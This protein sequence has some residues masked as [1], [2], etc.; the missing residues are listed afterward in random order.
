MKVSLH[1]V[2]VILLASSSFAQQSQQYPPDVQAY[3]D[4][5]LRHPPEQE[6][7]G[8]VAVVL[9]AEGGDSVVGDPDGKR[10]L[11]ELENELQASSAFY[12]WGES[13]ERL[14]KESVRVHFVSVE[15]EGANGETIGSA[16][17]L[18][19]A[20]ACEKDEHKEAV[21]PI[22]LRIW[23]VRHNEPVDGVL[24]DYFD[25]LHDKM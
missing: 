7:K 25:D 6:H 8:K 3:R 22:S 18:S 19:A 4:E 24:R 14:P 10:F 15:V 9:G 5:L 21:R 11:H 13:L 23:F 16:I 2:S 17:V 12:W 20:R 1:I